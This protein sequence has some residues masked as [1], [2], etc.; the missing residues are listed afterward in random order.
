ML[1]DETTRGDLFAVVTTARI[2]RLHEGEPSVLVGEG[3]AEIAALSFSPIVV[4]LRD[5]GTFVVGRLRTPADASI[6]E[7]A[8]WHHG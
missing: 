2:A 1:A 3:C 7:L 6:L 8:L 4:N 5:G